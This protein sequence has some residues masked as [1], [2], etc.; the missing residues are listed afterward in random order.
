MACTTLRSGNNADS[1]NGGLGAYVPER[2]LQH[3]RGHHPDP[4]PGCDQPFRILLLFDL[5]IRNSGRYPLLLSRLELPYTTGNVPANLTGCRRLHDAGCGNVS[6]SGVALS[7]VPNAS[8][9]VETDR[10]L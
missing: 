4:E 5:H 9:L 2:D 3:G 8:N 6:L 1:Y 10:L 7:S